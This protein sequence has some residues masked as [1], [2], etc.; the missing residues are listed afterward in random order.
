[1]SQS[2]EKLDVKEENRDKTGSNVKQQFYYKM[3][4]RHALQADIYSVFLPLFIAKANPILFIILSTNTCMALS[5]SSFS[6]V[7]IF[8]QNF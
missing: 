6:L 1:M 4:W 5:V 8:Q 2:A 3:L 7:L